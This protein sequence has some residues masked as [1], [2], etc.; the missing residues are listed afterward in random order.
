ML[1]IFHGDD[2][3]L[4]LQAFQAKIAEYQNFESLRF[5]NKNIDFEKLNQFV[6][7]Q[8]LFG[9]DKLLILDNPYSLIKANLDKLVKIILGNIDID[10]IIWQE[11]SLKP[12]ENNIFGPAKITKFPLD[13]KLFATLNA[14]RPGN[15]HAFCALYQQT[16]IQ[17]PFELFFFWLKNNIRKNLTTYSKFPEDRLKDTYLKLINME[18]QYKNGL[19][20]QPKESACLNLLVDLMA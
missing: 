14:L 15:I 12:T 20:M 10:I 3:Y 13:K 18:Y 9:N 1:Y 5:D 4:S 2:Q 11:R 6:N 19:L 17:E 7:S 16:I 8:S